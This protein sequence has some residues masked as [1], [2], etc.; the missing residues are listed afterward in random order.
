MGKVVFKNGQVFYQGKLQ[1]KDVLIEDEIIAS[2]EDVVEEEG[3]KVID[4]KNQ[5]L[6]LGFVD[7]HV[8]LREPGFEHKETI[9]TGT[10]AAKYG[11]YTHVVAMA[12]TNPCMD[13]LETICDFSNRVKRD[14][15]VHTYTYS[16]ITKG[17]QGNSLVDFDNISKEPII[18]GF[19]DDG[20]GVQS[21]TMMNSAMKKAKE[22]HAMIV[23]HCEDENELKPGA[24]IHD[25][26]YAKNHQLVGINNDS[27]FKQAR[28]DL[29]LAKNNK[30]RYHI[31]HIST[32]ETAVSLKEAKKNKLLTSGEV[33]PHHLILTDEN[34]KDCHPNYK[35]N[36]PLRS[37]EDLEALLEG[38]RDGSIEVIATDHAP[39]TRE[40]KN[41]P[42]DKAPFGIIGVQHSF[43]L[44]HTYLIKK[45]LLSLETVL[46]CMA[47][48]PARI[49]GLDHSFEVGKKANL[50]VIDLQESFTISEE[51]NK[52][53]SI[54]TPF[55]GVTCTGKV[56]YHVLDGVVTKL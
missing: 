25:G 30:C 15:K 27:E 38:L 45:G 24:C 44:I 56:M 42:I 40:E 20:K 43:S 3:A 6:T 29:E 51:N 36:P 28:R 53:K 10:L 4:I 1:N 5:I 48:N 23:A 50:C 9:A 55:L 12:N 7:M 39:H 26:T 54:N 34:I 16:A 49:L 47:V 35:M 31:C 17:L 2:I 33:C 8:H 22:N 32:K 21:E 37:K 11:G 52:S 14:A 19:S 41:V 46:T 18:L 13:S